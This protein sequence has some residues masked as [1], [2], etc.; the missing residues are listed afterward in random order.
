MK[1]NFVNLA[2]FKRSLTQLNGINFDIMFSHIEV[3][4]FQL[5]TYWRQKLQVLAGGG[6][7][8]PISNETR[9]KF[10]LNARGE[11]EGERLTRSGHCQH[12]EEER[13]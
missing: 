7:E 5:S 10:E 8:I 3:S 11:K 12:S 6:S 4:K 13:H 2:T 1:F 9:G